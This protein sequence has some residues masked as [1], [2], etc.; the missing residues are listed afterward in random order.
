VIH[1]TA[2]IGYAR[3]ADI[4]D[5]ARPDYPPQALDFFFEH[6]ALKTKTVL[7]VGAGT[8][9]LT[10][11]L[12]ARG[13]AVTAIEP[14]PAMRRNFQRLLP[15]IPVW[16][17]SAERIPFPQHSYDVICCAQSFH[18]F[19]GPLAL[20]EFARVLN[21]HGSLLLIWNIR[22][23]SVDWSEKLSRI[24]APYED[25]VPRYKSGQW[26]K[27]FESAEVFS[28]LQSR[29][30]PNRQIGSPE[31][32]LQRAASISFVAALPPREKKAVEDELRRLLATH[33]DLRGKS[34]IVWPYRTDVY[35]CNKR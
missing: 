33:P 10:K 16:E 14:V 20:R 28:P 25:R 31:L 24:I 21:P 15:G 4:Y 2:A 32:V 8:G 5:G 6:F 29:S 18:W 34:E 17:G 1:Q 35:W 11:L 13:A 9:K 30:F 3:A 7:E 23:A 26:K 27:A 19:N 22:D 12:L